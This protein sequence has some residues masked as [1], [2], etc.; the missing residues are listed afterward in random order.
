MKKLKVKTSTEYEIIIGKSFLDSVGEYVKSVCLGKNALIVSDDT[1]YSL[2][3]ERVKESL[4]KSGYNARTFVFEN[5]ER[6][7][8]M[9]TVL[10][11]ISRLADERFTRSD[12]IVALG[13]GVVGDI[14]GFAAAIYLR[15]ISFVQIPT[16]LLA[17]VDSSVGG[18]TGVDILQGK[19]LVGSFHQ[20]SLVLCDTAVIEKLPSEVYSDGMS[21]VIK[22][23]VICSKNIF[24]SV[25]SGS[26]DLEDIIYNCVCVKSEIVEKDEFDNGQRQLLNL[27]HT[28]GH[29]VEKLSN[30]TI[31]HGKGVAIGMV[32][33]AKFAYKTGICKDDIT[34]VLEKTLKAVNLPVKCDYAA[35]DM[36]AVMALDKKRRG[37][38]INLILPEKIGKAIIKKYSLSEFGEVFKNL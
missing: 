35:E 8:N 37:E 10:Q 9:Q 18:K 21:E 36:F 32:L 16:T 28:F 38:N 27:G 20:P 2:Y 6:S 17:A 14:S 4:E 26:Y 12:F 22:Y 11:I 1:V 33:A 23:G 19:N 29:A 13:G 5:G 15:G 31:S 7:K 3:G 34:L 24:D 25:S 30:F